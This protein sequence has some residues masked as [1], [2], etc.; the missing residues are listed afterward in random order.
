MNRERE[1]H[2]CQAFLIFHGFVRL[3][4]PIKGELVCLFNLFFS[5]GG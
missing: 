2:F 4:A 3:V 5:T 1:F